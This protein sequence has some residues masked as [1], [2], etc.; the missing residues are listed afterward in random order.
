MSTTTAWRV[1]STSGRPLTVNEVAKMHRLVWARRTAE[2]RSEWWALAIEAHLPRMRQAR[3]TAR[4]LHADRRSPQD[5]AACAP[6]V[7][8][9]IDGLVDARVL[10]DDDAGHLLAVTF[11]PPAVDGVDGLELVIEAVP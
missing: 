9:A 8:A 11:L 6:A 1:R 3:I 2:L 10:P 5:V 7:K 4:P